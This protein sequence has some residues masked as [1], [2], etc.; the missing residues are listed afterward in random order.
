MTDRD[1]MTPAERRAE[2]GRKNLA[3]YRFKKGQ[4]GNPGGKSTEQMKLERQN[5]CMAL[6]IR[7][8]M[9]QDIQS[10]IEKAS[11]ADPKTEGSGYREFPTIQHLK[12][13]ILKLLKDAE[14]RGLGTPVQSVHMESPDGTMSP[15]GPVTEEQLI[16][17]ARRL[18]IDPEALGLGGGEEEED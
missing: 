4:S 2:Q 8:A 15:D 3:P 10:E 12:P 18:G 13:E 5:A 11:E 6:E 7:N 9:L 16:E 17:R 1:N 14:D